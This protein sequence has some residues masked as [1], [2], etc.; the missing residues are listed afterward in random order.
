MTELNR[1]IRALRDRETMIADAAKE[2]LA[3][4]GIN[5][6][7][8]EISCDCRDDNIII[9]LR[10]RSENVNLADNLVSSIWQPKPFGYLDVIC[11]AVAAIVK[12]GAEPH[13][14]LKCGDAQLGAF[15]ARSYLTKIGAAD[16]TTTTNLSLSEVRELRERFQKAD[17][18]TPSDAFAFAREM[19]KHGCIMM[20]VSECGDQRVLHYSGNINERNAGGFW[21]DYTER[22]IIPNWRETLNELEGLLDG[23]KPSGFIQDY[24]HSVIH[25][26]GSMGR[27]VRDFKRKV[28]SPK[29]SWRMSLDY[30]PESV[31]FTKPAGHY[32]LY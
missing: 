30:A 3:R 15:P 4:A 1:R 10:I 20:F 5:T 24:V 25:P 12:F 21:W 22:S 29:A 27:H 6:S 17:F 16:M 31:E 28:W 2:Q 32:Q 18:Q 11:R 26:D 23:L 7:L 14:K 9:S 19:E 8:F 13:L